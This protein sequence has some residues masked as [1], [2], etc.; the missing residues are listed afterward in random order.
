LTAFLIYSAAAVLWL[1]LAFMPWFI[2]AE[3]KRQGRARSDEALKII[4]R[5]VRIANSP[6][7]WAVDNVSGIQAKIDANTAEEGST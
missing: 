1:I 2:Y 4:S 3:L 5:L 7:G 6:S